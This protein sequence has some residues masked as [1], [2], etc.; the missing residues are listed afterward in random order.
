[1]QDH[2]SNGFPEGFGNGLKVRGQTCSAPQPA[3]GEGWLPNAAAQ[4]Q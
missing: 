3:P 2:K 1:M 4:A